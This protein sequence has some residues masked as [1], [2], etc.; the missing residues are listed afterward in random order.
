MKKITSR[1]GSNNRKAN[2]PL[3]IAFLGTSGFI[4]SILRL[5]LSELEKKAGERQE[6]SPVSLFV[7]LYLAMIFAISS[8]N[9]FSVA[10]VSPMPSSIFCKSS[11]K[12]ISI[13]NF[14][15][16]AHTFGFFSCDI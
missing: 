15:W 16:E 12:A 11:M 1:E 9:A 13:S 4:N 3:L 10:L 2:I 14:F 8:F 5:R 7:F 6:G